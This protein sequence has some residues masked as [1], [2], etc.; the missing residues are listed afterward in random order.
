[1]SERRGGQITMG[2]LVTLLTA[3]VAVI[4]LIVL[5]VNHSIP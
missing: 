3:A 4:S 2:R 5:I 1:M